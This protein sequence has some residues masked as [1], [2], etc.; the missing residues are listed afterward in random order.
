MENPCSSGAATIIRKA[1]FKN[2]GGFNPYIRKWGTE[3]LELPMRLWLRG[4]TCYLHQGISIAH[5]FK[6]KFENTV[7]EGVDVVFNRIMFAH[8]CFQ[9]KKRRENILEAMKSAY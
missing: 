1:V 9:N 5:Y 3:D 8:T 2:V 6:H 7:V 4:Y